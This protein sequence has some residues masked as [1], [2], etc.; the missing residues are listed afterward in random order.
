[1]KI[2]LIFPLNMSRHS[3]IK[4]FLNTII[5]ADREGEREGGYNIGPPQPNKK[6]LVNK[7]ATKSQNRGPP[8]QFCPKSIDPQSFSKKYKLTPSSRFSSNYEFTTLCC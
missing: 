2:V 8:L 1:V 3:I 5:D 7:N 6:T 4:C